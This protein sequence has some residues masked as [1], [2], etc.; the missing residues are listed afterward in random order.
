MGNEKEECA[1]RCRM[2]P[3]VIEKKNYATAASAT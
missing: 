2:V 3:G 1:Q